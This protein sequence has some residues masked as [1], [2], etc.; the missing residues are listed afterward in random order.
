M[1]K[2]WRVGAIALIALPLAAGPVAG[3]QQQEKKQVGTAGVVAA[4][5]V[6]EIADNPDR[7]IGKTVAVTGPVGKL[8]GPRAFNIEEEGVF[9][10]D[11]A[12]IVLAPKDAP[13]LTEDSNVQVRGTIRRLVTAD[14]ERTYGPTYWTY[15]G[16]E[17][18]FFVDYDTR[19]VLFA[20]AVDVV[21]RQ[22]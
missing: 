11:D 4:T 20:D 6:N 9:D 8:F 7:Y 16:L 5:T 14:L 22:Q 3:Q 10:V 1:M 13:V 18:N 17:R 21:K 19:P 15:W 2:S 12:L